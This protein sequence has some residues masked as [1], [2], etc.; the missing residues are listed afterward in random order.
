MITSITVGFGVSETAI[1]SEA[2]AT[3]YQVFR[4]G[5]AVYGTYDP[6]GGAGCTVHKNGCGIMSIVNAVYHLNGN[7]IS[8][9]DLFDWAYSTGG[10][11]T[12]GT[13]RYTIYPALQAA[14]GA[15]YGFTVGTMDYGTVSDSRF[16]SHLQNGG[17]AIVHVYNHFMCIADYDSASGR[18]LLLDPSP[19]WDNRHSSAGGNWMTAAELTGGINSTYLNVD[20]WCLLSPA[21]ASCTNYTATANVTSGS[22]SVFFYDDVSSSKFAAGTTVFFRPVPANGYKVSS[23]TVNGTSIAVQNGGNPSMY[24]FTMPSANCAI[25]VNFTTG[26]SAISNSMVVA[27]TSY[28][29]PGGITVR[30]D[31]AQ[32]NSYVGLFKSSTTSYSKSTAVTYYS[33]PAY[34][35]E[36]NTSGQGYTTWMQSGKRGGNYGSYGST[37]SY[38]VLVFNTSGTVISN[39]QNITLSGS[40]GHAAVLTYLPD[41]EPTPDP[42]P[43]TYNLTAKVAAGE[44]TVHFGN[45]VTSTEVAAGTVVNYE[46]TPAD[47]WEVSQVL[48]YGTKQTVDASGGVYQFTM[49]AADATVSVTFVQKAA[50]TYTVKAEVAA[51]E[52]VVHFGDNIT[53]AQIAAGTVVNYQVTPA[54]GY[55]VS[56]VLIYGTKQNVSSEGGVY[57][58]TMEEADATVSVTFEQS[59]TTALSADDIVFDNN[60]AGAW[61]SSGA[62]NATS[63]AL[64][65]SSIGDTALTITASASDDPNITLDYSQLDALSASTYKYM[66]ITAKTSAS[67]T[68]AKMYLCPGSITSPT[69]DCATTWTWDNDG[70]WHEYVI[71]LS[72]LSTWSGALN[73]IRFDYFDGTTAAGS[74]LYLRSIRFTS[75]KPSAPTVKTDSSTFTVGADITATFS[76]LDSYTG[77]NQNAV[78]FIGVYKR[79]AEP[80]SEGSLLYTIV[81]SVSG[82]VNVTSTAI[83]GTSAG[84]TLPVGNYTLWLAYDATGSTENYNL[85]NVMFAS[86]SASCDFTIEEASTGEVIIDVGTSN[87]TAASGKTVSAAI[88]ELNTLL[89]ATTTVTK[90]GVEVVGTT[91]LGTGMVATANG[92]SYSIVIKGDVTGNGYVDIADAAAVMADIKGTSD[93]SGAYAQ[94]ALAC[95]NRTG[96]LSVL[97]V[98]AILNL[99]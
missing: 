36:N 31:S 7:I 88:I 40:D 45:N 48:I 37:G 2:A 23:I 39:I 17:T 57:Q 42:T 25:N 22:G 52:G 9:K 16:I 10:Y 47:G 11:G 89:G 68:S 71:D 76:G 53:S 41:V 64:E 55:K 50:T 34:Y 61:I 49:E 85:N 29:L 14:F 94:A 92:K 73:S 21:T 79:G 72:S 15:K 96:S 62:V 65:T 1:T 74:I 24:S 95:T 28:T 6:S 26:G 83:G 44:G 3:N 87:I 38:K 43:S 19:G 51:G 84:T 80:G 8:I 66:I 77:T 12:S 18:Y 69:E 81:S 97:E 78:F 86:S 56:Q 98:M 20:W 63:L 5:D 99:I 30:A 27:T 60:D 93:V 58:F 33:A 46:V 54:A 4:Q 75:T 13:T 70:L 91:T 32:P 67:N 82:S 35:F 90:D 59:Y